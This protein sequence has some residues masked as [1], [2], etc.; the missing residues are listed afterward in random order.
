MTP[1]AFQVARLKSAFSSYRFHPG[2]KSPKKGC[3]RAAEGW[4]NL[5][6]G[7]GECQF[8]S[9]DR[10]LSPFVWSCRATGIHSHLPAS[11]IIAVCRHQEGRNGVSDLGNVVLIVSK[12]DLSA[13]AVSIRGYDLSMLSEDGSI[14]RTAGTETTSSVIGSTSTFAI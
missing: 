8:D 2:E 11:E 10:G 7:A 13:G 1:L 9:P 6:A 3:R 4:R 12:I 5:Q 14:L